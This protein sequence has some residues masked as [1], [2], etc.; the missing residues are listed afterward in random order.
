MYTITDVEELHKWMVGHFGGHRSFERIGEMEVDRD[1]CA[2]AMK[3]ETEE[4][5]KVERNGGKKFVACFRRVEDPP[6][7]GEGENVESADV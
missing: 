5:K 6:W 1:K 2:A 3:G 4:G 7:P